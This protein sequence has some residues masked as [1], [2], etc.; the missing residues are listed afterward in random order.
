MNFLQ[1]SSD[2]DVLDFV[3]WFCVNHNK[4]KVN[5]NIKSSKYV[6]CGHAS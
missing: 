6:E 5:L 2:T 1:F 3:D 4:I